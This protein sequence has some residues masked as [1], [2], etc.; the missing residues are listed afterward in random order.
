[1]CAAALLRAGW[2]SRPAEVSPSNRRHACARKRCTPRPRA[3][4]YSIYIPTAR[5]SARTYASHCVAYRGHT[6]HLRI[7]H[8]HAAPHPMLCLHSA[9]PRGNHALFSSPRPLGQKAKCKFIMPGWYM[10]FWLLLTSSP[11][12]YPP[13]YLT[14]SLKILDS[15]PKLAKRFA[16]CKALQWAGG[17]VLFGVTQRA[18]EH[19]VLLAEG[20]RPQARHNVVGGRHVS[21]RL[22]HLVRPQGD[23]LRGVFLMA[24]PTARVAYLR[25]CCPMAVGNRVA[26]VTPQSSLPG[27]TR[28]TISV[29]APNKRTSALQTDL[30][31]C[32]L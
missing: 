17:L 10:R 31:P 20:V 22:A 4:W 13:Q 26:T 21:L 7:K 6:R 25:R 11:H 3:R 18:H 16:G 32:L 27:S 30:K 15:R 8:I 9:T 14:G 23:A 5:Q 19:L 12:A 29:E 2:V 28:A 24:V 1:M